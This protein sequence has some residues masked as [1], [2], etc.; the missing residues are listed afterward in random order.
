MAVAPTISAAGSA[1]FKGAPEPCTIVVFGAAGDLGRRRLMPSLFHLYRG[2]HIHPKTIVVGVDRADLAQDAFRKDVTKGHARAPGYRT[3]MLPKAKDWD[4]FTQQVFYLKGDVTSEKTIQ[5]LNALLL[6]LEQERQLPKRRMFYLSLPPAIFGNTLRSLAAAGL[7]GKTAPSGNGEWARVVVEKP[8]GRDLE[9]SRAFNAGAREILTEAEIFRIDPY[10]GKETV[11]NLLYFRFANS[12]FEPLWSQQHIDHVQI[13]AAESLGLENRAGYYETT[14]CLRDMVQTH[15]LQL[16]SLVAMEPPVAFD[17]QSIRDEKTKVLRCLRVIEPKDA[18]AET[19]RGQ[20]GEGRIGRNEVTPYR[21]EEGADP[22][23]STETYAAVRAYIDNWR[24]AG[25]PF[26]LRAGKRLARPTTQIVVTFKRTPHVMFKDLPAPP[27]ANQLILQIQPNDGLALRFEA[28]VPGADNEVKTVNM[29]FAYPDA[30]KDENPSA[31][32]R[33]LMDC[34]AGDQ[35][36]FIRD[37]EIDAAWR[38]V[39]PILKG[40]SDATP[41]LFPNYKAGTWGP[42]EADEWLRKDG[43]EWMNT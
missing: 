39:T 43:R 41:P 27:A 21:G 33:L 7:I 37:D 31:Y 18:L 25:T 10:L 17:A 35:T 9:S 36:L 34:I 3:M 15:I 1:A 4:E 20:Y 42:A 16:M 24:W 38:F 30:F 22:K 11:Q 2:D 26:Y 29:H 13:T 8:F 23:S 12:I 28:K 32:E 5:D 14:G 6:K 19:V 40:W